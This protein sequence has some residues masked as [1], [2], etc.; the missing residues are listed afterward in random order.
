VEEEEVVV[1]VREVREV[2]GV[3]MGLMVAAMEVVVAWASVVA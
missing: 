3:V 1:V 2:V